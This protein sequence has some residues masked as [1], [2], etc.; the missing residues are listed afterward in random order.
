MIIKQILCG[1]HWHALMEIER[2][3]PE[4]LFIPL[5]AAPLYC[6]FPL[7]SYLKQPETALQQSLLTLLLLT[8]CCFI[9]ALSLHL[10]MSV[11]CHTWSTEKDPP[12]QS[13]VTHTVSQPVCHLTVLKT[14]QHSVYC[15]LNFLID[16][17][18]MARLQ[19]T[20]GLEQRCRHTGRQLSSVCP[21]LQPKLFPRSLQTTY[22][23]A[24]RACSSS[25]WALEA[26]KNYVDNSCA[27]IW[28]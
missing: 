3:S 24:Q 15:T 28:F 16:W 10:P 26:E 18:Q 19:N 6:N 2:D 25:C 11:R 8:C 23:G 1:F 12:T 9:T 27:Y 22:W 17:T 14:N 13:S 7:E 21:P 20:V 4:S 5:E